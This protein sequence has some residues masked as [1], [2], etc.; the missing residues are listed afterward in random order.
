MVYCVELV[1]QALECVSS[2]AH[3]ENSQGGQGKPLHADRA[4]HARKQLIR[5]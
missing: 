2:A 5:T 3:F 4:R 1:A